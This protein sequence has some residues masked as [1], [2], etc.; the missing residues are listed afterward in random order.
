MSRERVQVR[1]E[2]IYLHLREHLNQPFRIADLCKALAITNNATTQR[3]I[4]RAREMAEAEGL[5]FP[6]A[7]PAN[8]FSYTVTDDPAAAFD[9]VLHLARIAQGVEATKQVGVDFMQQHKKELDP[10]A[11]AYLAFEEEVRD[12]LN[13]VAGSAAHITKVLVDARRRERS[14]TTPAV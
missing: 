5:H 7:C 4:R 9:P 10:A 14:E 8:D 3:A 12:A 13:R 2:R 1:A 6:V 11:S